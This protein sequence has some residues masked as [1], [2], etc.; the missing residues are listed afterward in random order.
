MWQG[1]GRE[2][3]LVLW[4]LET[5]LISTDP[6]TETTLSSWELAEICFSLPPLL[7]FPLL[8]H[9]GLLD[10]VSSFLVRSRMEGFPPPRGIAGLHPLCWGAAGAELSR[11]MGNQLFLR[12]FGMCLG[13]TWPASTWL[14]PFLGFF[15][16]RSLVGPQGD[17]MNPVWGCCFWRHLARKRS[18]DLFLLWPC[19]SHTKSKELWL[20]TGQGTVLLAVTGGLLR[21]YR[22]TAEGLI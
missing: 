16:V 13:R 7:A 18:N 11:T 6:A 17:T 19:Q 2:G 14:G 1:G 15:T 8:D 10:L 3:V 5:S 20:L 4:S 21:R 9:P 22:P 12:C